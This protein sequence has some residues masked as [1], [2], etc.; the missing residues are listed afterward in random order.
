MASV[1]ASSVLVGAGAGGME[2]SGLWVG[3]DGLLY[4]APCGASTVLVINPVTRTLSFID[5][6]EDG[7]KKYTDNYVDTDGLQ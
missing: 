3:P 1:Q 5:G 2:Y 6:A 7:R 4:C